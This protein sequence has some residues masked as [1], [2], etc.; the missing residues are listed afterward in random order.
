MHNTISSISTVDF[1][2]RRDIHFIG[3]IHGSFQ[4]IARYSDQMQ[5]SL[6]IQVGDFGAGFLHPSDFRHEMLNLARLLAANNN[7][8][9]VIR[10]NHDDPAYFNNRVY[11]GRVFLIS[12][13]QTLTACGHKLLLIGGAISVDRIDRIEGR[14]Y[15]S[16]EVVEVDWDVIDNV[17]D[18][19]GVVTHTCPSSFPSL[20]SNSGFVQYFISKGDT[21][22]KQQLDDEQRILQLVLER[23]L[24]N[25]KQIGLWVHGH[26]HNSVTS[27]GPGGLHTRCLAI[28]EIWSPTV[29]SFKSD[30]P[31]QG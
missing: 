1:S 2:D 7:K 17:R 23:L 25:N 9:V 4:T 30:S 18:L 8:L 20:K 29:Y 15:W 16:K 19:T 12:D 24:V 10:G 13:N 26:F 14:S 27:Q 22:L 28:D 31:L 5:D 11:D 3:D 21:H 6:L